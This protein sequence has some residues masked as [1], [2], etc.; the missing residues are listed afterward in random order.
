MSLGGPLKTIK[1]QES[2]G[3]PYEFSYIWG[4]PVLS[5]I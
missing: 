1:V 3:K 5:S 4:F 2:T